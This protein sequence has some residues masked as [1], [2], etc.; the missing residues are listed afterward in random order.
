LLTF[1]VPLRIGKRTPGV[2]G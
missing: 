2:L 1:N